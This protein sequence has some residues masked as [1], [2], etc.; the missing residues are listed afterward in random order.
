MILQH[1]FLRSSQTAIFHPLVQVPVATELIHSAVWLFLGWKPSWL[2]A[3]KRLK[4]HP[5]LSVC[6]SVSRCYFWCVPTRP[7]HTD[8]W[9]K[10]M[11]SAKRSTSTCGLPLSKPH[12]HTQVHTYT[13]TPLS[14][15]TQKKK[16]SLSNSS[17][18]SWPRLLRVLPQLLFQRERFLTLITPL[19]P[20]VLEAGNFTD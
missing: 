10:E 16:S 20:P 18:P 7:T 5:D 9:Q 8:L 2:L 17:S 15:L 4:S 6:P 13:H 19:P 11:A 3:L 12:T 1:L 14:F